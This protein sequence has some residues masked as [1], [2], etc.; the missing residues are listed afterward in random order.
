[1]CK[2]IAVSQENQTTGNSLKQEQSI[3]AKKENAPY[4][5]KR[6]SKKIEK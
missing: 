5:R 2:T 4:S 3:L 6:V 1:M